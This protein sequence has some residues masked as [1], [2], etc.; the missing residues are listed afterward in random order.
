MRMQTRSRGTRL[1][2]TLVELMIV[3]IIVLLLVAMATSAVLKFRNTGPYTATVMNLQ[4]IKAAFDTQWKAFRD[5]VQRESID[6]NLAGRLTMGAKSGANTQAREQ[7]ISRRLR[8]A[9]PMTFS[10]ALNPNGD[11]NQAAD[12][13]P[14]SFL[15]NY[16]L[17]RAN[18]VYDSYV[19]G[20]LGIK[21][22]K[23]GGPDPST[24]ATIAD[25]QV[26]SDEQKQWNQQSVLLLMI[27]ERG[28]FTAGL[29][30]DVL[31]TSA[32]LE[33]GWNAKGCVDAWGRPLLFAR[34]TRNNPTTT[35]DL[36]ILNPVILSM[37]PDGKAGVD[38]T[39]LTLFPAS[40]PRR[41]FA[42]DNVYTREDWL[43]YVNP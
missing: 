7:Y 39:T 21:L 37:G 22:Q 41:Q 15:Q 29:S 20:L 40:D 4:K 14:F 16:P 3:V 11:L 32:A 38:L 28:P 23:D 33:V 27:L 43:K 6:A 9:F 30:A 34:L 19:R 25:S 42:T 17:L 35:A 12:T 8:V 36:P 2:F 5:Q 1:G 10:E 18:S 31:G 26:G 13:P 24:A